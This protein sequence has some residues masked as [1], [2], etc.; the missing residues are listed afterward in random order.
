MQI[1]FFRKILKSSF[2]RNIF[3]LSGGTTIA[4]VIVVLTTPILSRL[5]NNPEAFGLLAIFSSYSVILGC[6]STGKYELALFMPKEDKDAL[7]IIMGISIIV[8]SFSLLCYIV[9]TLCRKCFKSNALLESGY[10]YYIFIIIVVIALYS[11]LQL[12]FQRKKEY[13]IVSITIIIQSSITV[14]SSMLLCIRGDRMFG[15]IEGHISGMTSGFLIMLTLFY[16]KGY[17]LT[18]REGISLIGIKNILLKYKSFPRTTLISEFLVVLSQQFLTILFSFFYADVATGYLSLSTRMLKLPIIVIAGSFWGVY[19][20][21]IIELQNNNRSIEH[22]YMSTLKKLFVIGVV[23]FLLISL[24]AP[25]LFAFFFGKDWIVAGVY[26]QFLCV[27]FF[28]DFIT[29]PLSSTFIVKN[30]PYLYLRIQLISIF[31]SIA[32]IYLG[33]ILFKDPLQS[34]LFYSIGV[35]VVNVTSLWFSYKLSLR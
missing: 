28:F 32:T 30:K 13:K 19:R 21:E 29:F 17:F 3:I 31:V 35:S 20:N 22:T 25:N 5:F 12:W 16:K 27:A 33:Y 23:P 8:T 14:L 26:S 7:N 24:F 2:N 1:P 6:L 34:I 9:F 18:M 15:L 10:I 11:S 4:Q